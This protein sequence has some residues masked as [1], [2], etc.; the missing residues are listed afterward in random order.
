MEDK[1]LKDKFAAF[2]PRLSSAEDFTSQLERRIEAVES[3]RE[4]VEQ[5]HRHYRQLLMLAFAFGLIVGIGVVVY[6]ATNPVVVSRL[7][8]ILSWEW[9]DVPAINVVDFLPVVTL[10]ILASVVAIVP[11]LSRR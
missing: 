3:V 4:Y 5:S 1:F 6:L 10:I 8:S 9:D 11:F 7:I 2:Q